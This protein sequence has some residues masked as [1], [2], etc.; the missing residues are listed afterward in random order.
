MAKDYLA[1]PGKLEFIFL[2]I[3]AI[4]EFKLIIFFFLGTS[5]DSERVFSSSKHTIP[6]TRCSLLPETITMCMMEKFRIKE[7]F[8]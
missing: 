2:L 6:E 4:I 1:V 7:T 5:V 3:K 8:F